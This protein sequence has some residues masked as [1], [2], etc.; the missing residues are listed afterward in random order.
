MLG[1]LAL[2]AGDEPEARIEDERARRGRALVD[3]E[4]MACG[5]HVGLPF[6][7]C[8]P[9]CRGHGGGDWRK[10]PRQGKA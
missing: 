5:G 8:G 1:E 6:C 10:R 2:R 7:G 9:S 3:R 4:E